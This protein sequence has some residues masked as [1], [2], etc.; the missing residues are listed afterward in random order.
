MAVDLDDRA[1]ANESGRLAATLRLVGLGKL[2][3]GTLTLVLAFTGYE[4]PKAV[5][6]GAFFLGIN[7]L[8]LGWVCL[9]L[10]RS[11]GVAAGEP[12][13]PALR[14]A[15]ARANKLFGYYLVLI[16]L[17]LI[18]VGFDTVMFLGTILAR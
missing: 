13:P 16:V 5:N 14:E 6:V 2:A 1:S 8:M 3:L 9:S 17:A 11:F 12:A 18:G 15:L 10:G 7:L 4:T